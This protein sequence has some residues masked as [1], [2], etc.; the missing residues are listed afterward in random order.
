MLIELTKQELVGNALPGKRQSLG[1]SVCVDLMIKNLYT[2]GVNQT[3]NS[4]WWRVRSAP[5]G[6]IGCGHIDW[7]QRA[8]L[9]TS[10]QRAYLNFAVTGDF[11]GL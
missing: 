11:P 1:E 3:G 2:K 6:L 5:V 10:R 4:F 9:Y 8:S 7:L